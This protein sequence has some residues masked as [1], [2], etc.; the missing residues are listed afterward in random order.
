MVSITPLLQTL[1]YLSKLRAVGFASP[2]VSVRPMPADEI[3]L[4]IRTETNELVIAFGM[5]DVG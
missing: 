5:E 4:S 3:A 1:L 2:S